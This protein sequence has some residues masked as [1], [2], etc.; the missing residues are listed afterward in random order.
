MA[1]MSKMQIEVETLYNQEFSNGKDSESDERKLFRSIQECWSAF[2]DV[3]TRQA[4][5]VKFPLDSSLFMIFVAMLCGAKS[6]GQIRDFVVGNVDWFANFIEMKNGVPSD[7]TFRRV[8]NIFRPE[9]LQ[10]MFQAV[11]SG[12]QAESEGNHLALD[13]KAVRGFFS[14]KSGRILHSVSLWNSEAGLSLGQVTTTNDA[15]KEEGEIQVIP[16]LLKKINIRGMVVTADAGAC[17][18]RIVNTIVEE[19]GDYVIAVKK[20]QPKLLE[21]ATEAFTRPSEVPCHTTQDKGHGRQ[22]TRTY[23]IRSVPEEFRNGTAWQKLQSVVRV[24]SSCISK[25]RTT[26]YV[27]YYI[28]DLSTDQLPEIHR[29]IRSHWS[30]ENQLHWSLDVTFGEDKQRT[31]RGWSAENLVIIRR[32]SI[33]A[34][35]SVGRHLKVSN[36]SFRALCNAEFRTRIILAFFRHH[37]T[38]SQDNPAQTP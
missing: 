17:Y 28:T 29:K 15:G 11:I 24:E 9:V 36:A 21:M 5:K 27:R 37:Q 20:N 19:G 2:L 4:S 22:E 7:D 14:S 25:D 12:I 23:S 6:F 1:K 10:E 30:I 16:E 32:A 34:I 33:S 3:D 38:H 35:N 13:G 8:V 26:T 18:P 31:R